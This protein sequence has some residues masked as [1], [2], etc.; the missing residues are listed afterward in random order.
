M[1]DNTIRNSDDEQEPAD[2]IETTVSTTVSSDYKTRGKKDAPNG[3]GVL[4]HNTATSGAAYGLEGVTDSSNA[5]AAGVSAN[6]PNGAMGIE[7]IA[8]GNYAIDA[9]T[10]GYGAIQG[11]TDGMGYNGIHGVNNA[12][13][14]WSWGVRG[15]THS[16]ADMG[17]GVR[18]EAKASSG[19]PKGVGGE[20]YAEGDGAAGV[21]GEASAAGGQTYGVDG[22]TQ[23]TDSEA[24]GIR[25]SSTADNYGVDGRVYD[26]ES[27]LPTLASFESA[28]VF[29][30]SD[31]SAGW[32]VAGWSRND[33]GMFARTDD[34][35]SYGLFAFNSG[36]NG[37]AVYANGNMEIEG[38]QDVTK[39]GL[40]AYLSW[41]QTVDNDTD[42]TVAFDTTNVDHFGGH[43]T[44]T[45]EYTIQEDGDYHVSFTI[46]WQTN[47]STGDHIG[48]ELQINGSINGGIQADTTAATDGQRVCR[49]YSRTLFDLSAGDVLKVVVS[50]VSG[51]TADIWGSNQES[52][53]TIYKVG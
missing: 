25:G 13:D 1:A 10:S 12:T 48:Y 49:C 9:S 11:T 52:Y 36:S 38:H 23:S 37:Y 17:F 7:A 33:N 44:S 46:D 6:A 35:S 20:T 42:T 21:Y 40:S 34:A 18:G 27:N 5:S 16:T 31:K 50:Q 22:V 51:S 30:R 8:N 41:K 45:G 53:L 3:T 24:A 39:T 47:F 4:G 14:G 2:S 32:G 29:G 26:D 15:D 43:N 19:S 28:G